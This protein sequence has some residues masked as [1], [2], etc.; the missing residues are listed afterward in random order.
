MNRI[1]WLQNKKNEMDIKSLLCGTVTVMPFVF[2]S[3]LSY[4]MEK[5]ET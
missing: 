2:I 4:Q 1:C 3:F 5:N